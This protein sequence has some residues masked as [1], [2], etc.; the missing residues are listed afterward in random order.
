MN[1]NDFLRNYWRYYL[2]LEERFLTLTRFIE[3]V[4]D[5]MSTYSLE[6][7]N[8][9][10]TLGSELDVFMKV[11]CNLN[12]NDEHHIGEYRP[13]ILKKYPQ[14]QNQEVQFLND[15]I[16]PFKNWENIAAK[17]LYWWKA[18]NLVKHGREYNFKQGN[19]KMVSHS[20]AALYILEKYY[21]KEITQN[22]NELDIPDKDSSIFSLKDWKTT[23]ISTDSLTLSIDAKEESINLGHKNDNLNIDGG[24]A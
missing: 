2:L 13:I 20:L 24:G 3:P 4:Y 18:Y 1:R 22:T 11:I 15:Y 19:L 14:I 21:L 7:V 12:Q 23:Y 8:Q 6:L 5:N 10:L 9:L 17:K 16:T